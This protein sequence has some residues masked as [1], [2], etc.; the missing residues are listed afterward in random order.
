[1]SCVLSDLQK[2]DVEDVRHILTEYKGENVVEAFTRQYYE[3][4]QAARATHQMEMGSHFSEHD[5][6]EYD[7]DDDEDEDDE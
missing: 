1:M 6:D 3:A 5:A 2:A 7:D 4:I